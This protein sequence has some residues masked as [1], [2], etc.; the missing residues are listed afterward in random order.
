MW[1]RRLIYASLSIIAIA[2]AAW[3]ALITFGPDISFDLTQSELQSKLDARFPAQKCLQKLTCFEL[4]EPVV[5]LQEGSDRLG[6]SAKFVATLGQR[7]MPG[8]VEF[9]AKPRYVQY[10][11][12]FF[13]DDI[14][15]TEFKMTGNAPDFDEMVKARGPLALR[16]MLQLTPIYRLKSDSNYG[17]FAK[18]ALREVKVVNGKLRISFLGPTAWKR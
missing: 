3:W 4:R 9:T 1:K 18:L 5:T 11:G 17:A 2:V 8:S 15:V 14:K 6:F 13:L 10:D 16:L 12:T 7:Q